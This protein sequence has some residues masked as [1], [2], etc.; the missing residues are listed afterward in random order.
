MNFFYN[1]WRKLLMQV[2]D[3]KTN[4]VLKSSMLEKVEQLQQ[5]LN[6]LKNEHLVLGKLPNNG[7]KITINGL[8]FV[9]TYVDKQFSKLHLEL[10]RFNQEQWQ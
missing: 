4:E 9:V 2:R 10:Y 7:D 1:Q 5:E 3:N 6:K 8:E